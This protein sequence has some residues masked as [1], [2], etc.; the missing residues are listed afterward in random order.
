M[1]VENSQWKDFEV[2]VLAENNFGYGSEKAGVAALSRT[3]YTLKVRDNNLIDNNWKYI[4]V[5]DDEKGNPYYQMAHLKDV[6]G[7]NVKLGTFY[8]KAD[9]LTADGD[10]STYSLMQQV[11]LRPLISRRK[12]GLHSLVF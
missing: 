11:G 5:K 3:V 10:T 7:K 1:V 9:Q 2:A 4:V 8:F 6:D 12:V